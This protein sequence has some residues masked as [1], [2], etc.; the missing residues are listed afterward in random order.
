MHG[1][2]RASAGKISQRPDVDDIHVHSEN[3]LCAAC[4]LFDDDDVAATAV[5]GKARQKSMQIRFRPLKDV[6]HNLLS[7][8]FSEHKTKNFTKFTG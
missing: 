3:C 2:N 1:V 4:Q 5:D 8:F 6:P 7:G